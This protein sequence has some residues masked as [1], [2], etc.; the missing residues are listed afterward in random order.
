M[1]P[2]FHLNDIEDVKKF[3]IALNKSLKAQGFESKQANVLEA[4]SHAH[5]FN[6][7]NGFCAHLKN[8]AKTHTHPIE[9]DVAWDFKNYIHIDNGGYTIFYHFQSETLRID[10]SFHGYS[11]DSHYFKMSIEALNQF[12]EEGKHLFDEHENNE[13]QLNQRP[14]VSSNGTAFGVRAFYLTIYNDSNKVDLYHQQEQVLACFQK[15]IYR[16]HSAFQ[17]QNNKQQEGQLSIND[18]EQIFQIF[19]HAKKISHQLNVDL[20]S[21]LEESLQQQFSLYAKIQATRQFFYEK[22]GRVVNNMAMRYDHSYGLMD[23]K[24]AQALKDKMIYVCYCLELG[25]DN[26]TISNQLQIDKT[27]MSQLREEW[28][29]Q[30]SRLIFQK[31]KPF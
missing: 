18:V 21:I 24:K 28:E 1:L 17:S 26:L 3:T 29:D 14:L 10:T 30:N 12:I 6:D 23:D 20:E 22:Q 27:T 8:Q 7:W 15:I 16:Y 9:H 13:V 4:I 19:S 25:F 2:E 5:G 11:S 31:K